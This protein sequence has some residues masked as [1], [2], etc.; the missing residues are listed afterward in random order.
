MNQIKLAK[1]KR[2]K[3]KYLKER[4]KLTNKYMELPQPLTDPQVAQFEFEK[5]LLRGLYGL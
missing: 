4:S 1:Q 3:K 5:G 2:R